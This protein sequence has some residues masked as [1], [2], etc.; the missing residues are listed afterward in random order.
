MLISRSSLS[1]DSARLTASLDI[2][3]IEIIAHGARRFHV[4][5][6]SETTS[7]VCA[8]CW[9]S[10]WSEE[11]LRKCLQAREKRERETMEAQIEPNFAN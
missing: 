9:P 10:E 11:A 6:S 4:L 7:S 2:G 3:G 5:S 8:S 1:P